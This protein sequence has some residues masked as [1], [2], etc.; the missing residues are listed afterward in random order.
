MLVIMKQG[1]TREDCVRVEDAIRRLGCK[2]LEVPGETRVAICVTG[3]KGPVDASLI[4]RLP[5]VLECIRV[6]KPWK[7]VSREVHPEDSK[8]A[9]GRGEAQVVIGGGAPVLMAGP[10]SCESEARTI[11]IARKVKAA[12]ATIF[13]AGAYKPR[14]SPYDFQGLGEEALLTLQR[15]RD[16]VGLAVVTEVMDAAHVD[17]VERH[18]DML[19][20]GTRNMHNSSLLKRLAKSQKP[21]MLKRGLSATLDEWLMAAEYLIAGGN[22]NVVLCERGVRTFSKH[23]RNTLDLNVVPHVRTRS[24]LPI[25]VDPSHGIGVRE[26]VRTMSRAALAAGAQGLLLET[27]FDP[28]T[29]YTDAQQTISVETFEGIVRDRDLLQSLERSEAPLARI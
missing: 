14:T 24:H 21:I 3:N 11:E 25:V 4:A 10:C 1:C 28:D 12:G 19:Q 27:H 15:V 18:A 5:G 29:S 6:T 20:V 13:R 7:L 2:P 17:L 23:S 9:V 8:I 26:M 22:A 16:E